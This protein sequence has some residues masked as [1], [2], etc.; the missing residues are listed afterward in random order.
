[1]IVRFFIYGI[2]YLML[3][4][5]L[6]MAQDMG[7]QAPPKYENTYL[8]SIRKYQRQPEPPHYMKIR[9]MQIHNNPMNEWTPHDSL[10]YAYESVYLQKYELAYSIFSRLNM[11][12]VRHPVAQGLYRLTMHKVGRFKALQQ[13]NERTLPKDTNL[14][15]SLYDAFT[16]LNNAYIAKKKGVF[17]T[18]ST[19]IFTILKSERIKKARKSAAPNKNEYALVSVAIDSALR[20]YAMFN[21]SRDIVLGDA[22][23]EMGD[24]QKEY[25]YITNAYFY[26][27]AGRH[28]NISDKQLGDK[29]NKS[30]Y[31]MRERDY[32][33]ISF[34]GLFGKVVKN[35]Y[36]F[37]DHY[38]EYEARENNKTQKPKEAKEIKKKDFIPWL[39]GNLLFLMGIFII[40]MCILFF[41]KT[42]KK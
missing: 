24:F 32:L 20:Q 26:Y 19:N 9:I 8:F 1:M 23:E 35:R 40:L 37:H 42:K 28:Y 21:D 36:D 3:S 39:D 31:I 30:I 29:Y 14:I 7:G 4:F 12:S 15:Y 18:D 16:D 34:K 13:Y 5:S 38:I 33:Q 2:V 17:Y 27:S 10:F 6:V 41:L 25:L 11:D 22:F